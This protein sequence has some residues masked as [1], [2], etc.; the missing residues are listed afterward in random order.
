M[1]SVGTFSQSPFS[2]QAQYVYE[3]EALTLIG[4]SSK[5]IAG[6]LI[7]DVEATFVF[8]FTQDTVG[9]SILAPESTLISSFDNDITIGRTR[10]V[11]E[12]TLVSSFEIFLLTLL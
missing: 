2:S 3:C 10:A 1:F 8:S 11:F 5:L 9:Q 6:S 12:P 7:L 4:T